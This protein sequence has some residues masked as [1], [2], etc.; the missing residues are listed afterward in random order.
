[1]DNCSKVKIAAW[2]FFAT[3]P[4]FC[5][6]LVFYRHLP[7]SGRKNT[8]KKAPQPLLAQIAFVPLSLLLSAMHCTDWYER[9]ALT[10]HEIYYIKIESDLRKFP[11]GPFSETEQ[12]IGVGPTSSSSWHHSKS[13]S[14]LN[15]SQSVSQLV[16]E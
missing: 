7:N 6:Q 9:W 13:S 2:R 5:L 10:D 12:G 8:V 3:P 11:N 4:Y 16:S 1:M 15:R 14:L